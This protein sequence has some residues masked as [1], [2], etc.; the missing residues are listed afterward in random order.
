MPAEAHASSTNGI[1]P[2][3]VSKF[4]LESY[5]QLNAGYERCVDTHTGLAGAWDC[6]FPPGWTHQNWHL[7]AQLGTSGYYQLINDAG[8]CLGVFSGS[9]NQGALITGHTCNS[10]ALDQYWSIDFLGS[11][12]YL[13]L[14]FNYNSGYVLD[15]KGGS[16]ANGAAIQQYHWIGGDQNQQWV[17]QYDS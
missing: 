14:V 16:L 15:L 8:Q 3:V 1:S 7:G 6:T 10:Q 2:A 17:V 9:L 11:Q 4:Q 5:K 13:C 12:T